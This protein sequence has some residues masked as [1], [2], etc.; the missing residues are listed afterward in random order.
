MDCRASNES[1]RE[2]S[3]CHHF[4]IRIRSCLYAFEEH[5]VGNKINVFLFVA[6]VVFLPPK[7]TSL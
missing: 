1:T 6:D 7:Q 2:L 4:F 5:E 3:P